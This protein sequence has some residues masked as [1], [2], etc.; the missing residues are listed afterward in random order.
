M[1][2]DDQVVFE[3]H[4]KEYLGPNFAKKWSEA[5]AKYNEVLRLSTEN[6]ASKATSENRAFRAGNLVML[7]ALKEVGA[8]EWRPQKKG[9][10]G[11]KKSTQRATGAVVNSGVK[12]MKPLPKGMK[13]I[14]L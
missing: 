10:N 2:I 12:P 6:G 8:Q 4:C 1:A 9:D 13:G 14:Q 7:A 3:K 11:V 5:T